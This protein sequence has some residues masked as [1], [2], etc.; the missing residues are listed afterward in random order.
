MAG[1]NERDD[2]KVKYGRKIRKADQ[3]DGMLTLCPLRRNDDERVIETKSVEVWM[4]LPPFDVQVCKFEM[5]QWLKACDID[6]AAHRLV[7]EDIGTWNL[8]DHVDKEI[9][10]AERVI[11]SVV[12]GQL[13]EVGDEVDKKRE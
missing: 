4:G 11:E 6:L 10:R 12:F 7:S 1:Y 9:E 2:G 5:E 13:E 8:L 3:R